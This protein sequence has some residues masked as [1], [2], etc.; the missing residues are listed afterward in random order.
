[1][2]EINTNIVAFLVGFLVPLALY[3]LLS[4][5][6]EEQEEMFTSQGRAARTEAGD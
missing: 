1:M 6:K 3:K 2:I 5:F 4:L